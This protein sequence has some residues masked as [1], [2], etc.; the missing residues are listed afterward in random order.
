MDTAFK[1]VHEGYRQGKYGFPDMLDAQRGLIEATGDLV[2]ALT[3]YH[4]DAVPDSHRPPG[5]GGLGRVPRAVRDC[6]R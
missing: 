6:H 1:A 3:D 2:D 5:C 4:A